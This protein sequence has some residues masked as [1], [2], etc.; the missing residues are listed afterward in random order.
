MN[1]VQRRHKQVNDNTNA[2]I[3][4][5]CRIKDLFPQNMVHF[6]HV[7]LHVHVPI[8]TGQLQTIYTSVEPNYTH[9]RKY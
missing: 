9:R 7:V 2:S 5:T 1:V 8:S 3:Y 4:C 6:V